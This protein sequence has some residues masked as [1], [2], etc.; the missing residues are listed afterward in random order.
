[1]LLIEFGSLGWVVLGQKSEDW[2]EFM[3]TLHWWANAFW[4]PAR[5]TSCCLRSI[6]GQERSTQN[7]PQQSPR[8]P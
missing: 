2:A 3:I 5:G 8:Q 6:P 7:C 1:M 4:S